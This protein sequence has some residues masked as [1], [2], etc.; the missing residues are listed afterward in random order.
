MSLLDRFRKEK[1]EDL[2]EDS[3]IYKEEATPNRLASFMFGF[4]ALV[5]TLLI[6][7]GLFFGVRGIYRAVQG[8][9]NPS[10]TATNQSNNKDNSGDSSKEKK[11][12]ATSNESSSP[13]QSQSGGSPSSTPSTGDNLPNTGDNLTLPKTGDPGM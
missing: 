12:T 4:F 6:A 3:S 11:K 2:E 9:D 13:H 8:N 10:T 5:L 1:D 7:G